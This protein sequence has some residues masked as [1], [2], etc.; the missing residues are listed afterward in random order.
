MPKIIEQF[1][2]GKISEEK[3]EDRLVITDD[4]VAVIDGV[5]SKSSYLDDGKTTGNIAAGLI[6]DV[7]KSMPFDID[8][9]D[10]I[11]SVNSSYKNYYEKSSFDLDVM[12]YGLQAMAVVFSKNAKEI[13]LIGDC[14][15]L[16]NDDYYTNPKPSDIVLEELRSLKAHIDL[17]AKDMSE[18]D[19]F[20]ENEPS[21]KLIEQLI[22]DATVFANDDSSRWGYSVLN[23]E[24]IPISLCKIINVKN[25]DVVVLAS[26]GYPKVYKSL[27]ES[28]ENL[29]KTIEDDPYFYKKFISTKG[30]KP[31]QISYDDRSYVK[32]EV[33]YGK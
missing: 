33:L 18:K 25:K 28:E 3:C 8:L 19:Y 22:V 21:R 10:F 23:G 32:F 7:I 26:D 31:G 6:E 9:N 11:E 16:I 14:V 17:K 2:K 1:I 24:D 12:K 30:L 27:K 20:D 29:K 13:W 5:S 4:F 15:A